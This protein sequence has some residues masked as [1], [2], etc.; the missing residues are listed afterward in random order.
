MKVFRIKG[1][2]KNYENNR[3]RTMDEMRWVPIPNKFD[4][5][6]Y[7][8]MVDG[9]DGASIYGA[10]VAI[11]A[12]A[13]KCHPRGTLVR[14]NGSAHTAE[15]IGRQTRLSVKSIEKALQK[16]SSPAV[17]WMEVIEIESD[18]QACQVT[19]TETSGGCGQTTIEGNGI[20]W[21]GREG[22]TESAQ[23][24]DDEWVK[25]L[26]QDLT[27][28]GIDVQREYL[29]M[30]KWCNV[31]RKQPTRKRFINWLNRVERPLSASTVNKPRQAGI[32]NI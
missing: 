30:L 28:Q 19:V 17:S 10:W 11:V 23:Q 2:D 9:P 1:W 22:A 14:Q 5:D 7:T 15:T 27:Y 20:E 31:N 32:P 18:A 6:G 13:S 29:K 24:T 12:V 16:A 8:E 21:K 3:T 4:G 25:E 26:I